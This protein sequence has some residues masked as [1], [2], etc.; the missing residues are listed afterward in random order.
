MLVKLEKL[1][2]QQYNSL[3]G[4]SVLVTEVGTGVLSKVLVRK[5]RL[6]M[7]ISGVQLQNNVS[8]F[9]NKDNLLSTE[10]K[11]VS[12]G[13]QVQIESWRENY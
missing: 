11:A 13:K 12:Q 6:Y 2:L 1:Y 3:C 7:G 8:G 10:S 4:N 9:T 5:D